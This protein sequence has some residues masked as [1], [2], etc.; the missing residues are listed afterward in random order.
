MLLG[1]DTHHARSDEEARSGEFIIWKATEG[2]TFIDSRF[3]ALLKTRSIFASKP[4]LFG[5]YH[6]LSEK[7][8]IGDQ[9]EHYIKTI[10]PLKGYVM[11]I[12]DYEAQFSA[13]DPHGICLRD[14]IEQMRFL[15]K[16][17]QYVIYMNKSDATKISKYQYETIV[18]ANDTCLWLADYNGS[19]KGKWKPIMRQVCTSPCDID[20]F[21]GSETS[22]RM[23]AQSWN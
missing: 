5:A 12:L 14:A 11:L 7:S 2:S 4:R 19:Y 6:F 15:A 13:N 8:R 23:I 17:A 18:K 10:Y 22:W 16:G 3:D 1:T 9:I 21:Y 20:V